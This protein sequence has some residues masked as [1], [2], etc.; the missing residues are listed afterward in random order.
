[1]Q[2]D[3]YSHT[4]I[5]GFNELEIANRILMNNNTP[6]SS[7]IR[8]AAYVRYSSVMQNDTF[9]LEAQLRQIKLRAASDGIDIVKVYSDPANSAYKK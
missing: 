3:L 5:A 1:M 2:M 4:I 8:A 9:T 7:K 6:L